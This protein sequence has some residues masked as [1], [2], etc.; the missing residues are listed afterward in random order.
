MHY[1]LASL[2]ASKIFKTDFEI[3]KNLSVISFEEAKEEMFSK[4]N[5]YIYE[6]YKA[7]EEDSVLAESSK[8]AL[9][10][11][12]VQAAVL[13]SFKNNLAVIEDTVYDNRGPLLIVFKEAMLDLMEIPEIGTILINNHTLESFV[14]GAMPL[15]NYDRYD[16]LRI[17]EEEYDKIDEEKMYFDN[18]EVNDNQQDFFL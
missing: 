5:L 7:L 9:V 8:L 17:Y 18:S 10:K 11:D 13:I 6:K 1:L 14:N 4:E 15:L 12:K 2:S 3:P 16:F